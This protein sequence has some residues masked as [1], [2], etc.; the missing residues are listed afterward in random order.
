MSAMTKRVRRRIAGW[1]APEL[2]AELRATRRK[3]KKARAE[4]AY[5]LPED[6]EATI[7][8]VRAEH[9]TYLKPDN[10]RELAGAVLEENIPP[11]TLTQLRKGQRR[12]YF[13][14]G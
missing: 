10:L 7:A 5:D 8:A 14:D 2:E 4:K 3:L 12:S 9:L 11:G 6:V 1:I 13:R